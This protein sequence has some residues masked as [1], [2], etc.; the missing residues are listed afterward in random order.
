[1]LHCNKTKCKRL[2][3]ILRVFH[4]RQVFLAPFAQ[5]RGRAVQVAFLPVPGCGTLCMA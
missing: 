1:M 3:K 5:V 2:P 4:Y